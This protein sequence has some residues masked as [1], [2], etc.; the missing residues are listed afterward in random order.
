MS[1]PLLLEVRHVSKRFERPRSIA[2][3]ALGLPASILQAVR[4][5]SLAVA[6]GETL[7]L[8]GESGCGKSTLGRCIA[9]FHEPSSG[10]V[11]LEGRPVSGRHYDRRDLSRRV[12][13]IF[14]DPYSSLNPRLT[15]GQAL[16]EVLAVHRL[17][18]G[19]SSIEERVVELLE[20][21]GLPADA[22]DKLPYAF[23]GGQRQRISIARALAAEPRLIVADEP[24]SALD[25]SIQAQVLNLF[26]DL[27][28]RLGLAFL[29]IAHDLNVVRH[30]SR[31]IAVMYLGEIV[32]C[33]DAEAIF[34]DPR[35]PYTKALLSAIPDPD[36]TH[37]TDAVSLAGELPDPSNPP[38]GCGL[39]TR[40]PI[41]IGRCVAEHPAL[42]AREKSEVRCF[43]A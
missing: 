31:R 41:R 23:S 35:H 21:V 5:V 2:D 27:Q 24:V 37:R 7:G 42:E 18:I 25:V 12:Q 16:R 28:K 29:F 3:A 15:I 19:R 40:C 14:Q 11:L 22:R 39:V 26:E 43:L 1:K 8:V 34:G 30:I 32:E 33:A 6:A 38:A 20:I 10:E 17:R 9:G 13:M 36:P 4:D